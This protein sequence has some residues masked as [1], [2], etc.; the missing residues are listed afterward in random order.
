MARFTLFVDRHNGYCGLLE[1]DRLVRLQSLE[2]ANDVGAILRAHITKRIE[3]LGG[4]EVMI[5][6][7]EYGLLRDVDTL[8]TPKSGDDV[9]VEVLKPGYD[10]KLPLLT[11]RIALTSASF[12]LQRGL[13]GVTVSRKINEP[14]VVHELS[15]FARKLWEDC[16]YEAG[17]DESAFPYGLKVRT[18]VQ[19]AY[20]A[21]QGDS[22]QADLQQLLKQALE[23]ERQRH[24]QPTPKTLVP[25]KPI[26]MRF[27]EDAIP[28]ASDEN[29]EVKQDRMQM[30]ASIVTD[31]EAVCTWAKD[32]QVRCDYDE[33]F[34]LFLDDRIRPEWDRWMRRKV[35]F[36]ESFLLVDVL[37]TLTAI[38]V[39]QGSF[40]LKW[41]KKEMSRRVNLD[42]IPVV[43]KVL[44]LREVR[45]ILV[46]DFIRMEKPDGK[47]VLDALEKELRASG[48]QY[49]VLGFTKAG[50]VE[51]LLYR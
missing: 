32:I 2:P 46:I 25:A 19:S 14:D 28:L 4:F 50:L 51:V 13:I 16:L 22:L 12:V 7:D 47:E 37:E 49:K 29:N 23:M 36:G 31:D 21:N 17:V 18:R 35:E 26:W 45:G 42:A 34:D 24:F 20:A 6:K 30:D 11:E 1:R 9:I 5:G 10:G 40:G 8:T 48:M 27:F 38:D 41:K 15:T 33:T 3:P 44:Q 43:V 39:N